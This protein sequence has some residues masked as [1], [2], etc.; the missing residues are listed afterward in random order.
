MTSFVLALVMSMDPTDGFPLSTLDELHFFPSANTAKGKA[1]EKWPL[2]DGPW[3]PQVRVQLSAKHVG[4]VVFNAA[5]KVHL[6]VRTADGAVVQD[7]LLAAFERLEGAYEK[8]TNSWLIKRK[9]A[10]ELIT[11]TF[12]R[13]FEFE[14]PSVPG[15]KNVTGTKSS[16]FAF[17]NGTFEFVS[18]QLPAGREFPLKR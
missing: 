2:V 4:Y 5:G 15:T 17:K 16:V 12:L 1:L 3:Y 9:G 18:Q 14:D 11:S 8:T 7:V 6:V 10:W 13:D